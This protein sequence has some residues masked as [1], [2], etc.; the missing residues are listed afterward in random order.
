MTKISEQIK[1]TAGKGFGNSSKAASAPSQGSHSEALALASGLGGVVDH[2]VS[3]LGLLAQQTDEQL[4]QLAQPVADYFSSVA[5]GTA[6]VG[7]VLELMH[8][9]SQPASLSAGFTVEAPVLP[10][11][12]KA[13]AAD[14]FGKPKPIALPKG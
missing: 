2:Q 4:T 6:L 8:E 14:F 13:T 5:D 10:A 7:K 3:E 11:A 12:P 9:K 1:N